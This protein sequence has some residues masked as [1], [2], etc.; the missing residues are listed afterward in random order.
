[1]YSAVDLF[2][3]ENAGMKNNDIEV[4]II[5]PGEKNAGLNSC[6]WSISNLLFDDKNQREEFR[7]KIHEAFNTITGGGHYVIFSDEVV[8]EE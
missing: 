3:Q 7:E 1:M 2:T 4:Y 8:S 5:F 6:S